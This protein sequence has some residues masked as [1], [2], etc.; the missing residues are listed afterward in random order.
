MPDTLFQGIFDTQ[1]TAVIAPEQF[2]L[3]VGA[4]LVIGLVL[5]AMM[6]WRTRPSTGFAVTLATLPAVVCVVIMMVNGNVG[7]GVAV[8]GA[9]SLVRFRSAP[10]SA[11]EIG[12]I[13][14]AMGAGLMAGMG[15]LGYAALFALILGGIT[16][17]YHAL[18]FGGGNAALR[19]RTLHITIPEDLDY[20]GVFDPILAQYA[21]KSELKQVK[22][23]N[24]GSLFK[25]TYDL[26]LRDG[27][28]EKA[29][30]DTAMEIWRS[31]CASR[32]PD[33]PDYEQEER[34]E[35]NRYATAEHFVAAQ[36]LPEH[37]RRF[38]QQHP[39]IG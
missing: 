35:T 32:R 30:I 14:A 3:C 39:R 13:F 8:A 6:L 4:S 20:T 36:W 15:Y 28:Q 22:T 25:L 19:C 33:R 10:G 1:L 37:R 5:C 17:A 23:T 21:T 29:L 31:P 34:Y 7:A 38:F 11:R 18:G 16:M 2:L 12:A 27:G 26:T 9:F 24:M